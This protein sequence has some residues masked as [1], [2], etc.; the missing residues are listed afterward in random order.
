M[1]TFA[2]TSINFPDAFAALDAAVAQYWAHPDTEW[3]E[4]FLLAWAYKNVDVR[5][6]AALGDDVGDAHV[7]AYMKWLDANTPAWIGF[8]NTPEWAPWRDLGDAC[9]LNRF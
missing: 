9:I 8:D 1:S 5:L 2:I 4:N 3:C 7:F 6:L